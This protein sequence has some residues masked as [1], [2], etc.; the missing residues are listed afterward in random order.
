MTATLDKAG[1]VVLPKKLR[2]TLRLKAGTLFHFDII[3]DKIQMEQEV[4]K[5]KIVRN[6]KGRRVVMGWEGFDA[7]K[8]VL[9]DREEHLQRISSPRRKCFRLSF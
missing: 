2:E 1:R 9:E 8:A 6:S 5:V 7:A 3:G 4:P